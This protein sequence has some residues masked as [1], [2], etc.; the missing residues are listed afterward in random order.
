MWYDESLQEWPEDDFRIFCGDLGNE[1]TD[2]L[3][4]NSFRKYPSFQKAKVIRDKKSGKTKGFGFVSFGNPEDM[5]RALKEVDEKYVGNRPIKLT[6]SK[7]KDRT[8]DSDKNKKVK[9]FKFAISTDN[10]SKTKFKKIKQ[11]Q[12]P[13]QQ[14]AKQKIRNQLDIDPQAVVQNAIYMKKNKNVTGMG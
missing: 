5:V 8:I 14:K 1:V 10:K 9:K 3:L 11:K 13:A 7:W 4:A 2:D 6:K 12:Y